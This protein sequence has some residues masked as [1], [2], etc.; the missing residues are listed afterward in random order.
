MLYYYRMV[1]GMKGM[2]QMN[3]WKKNTALF[4]SSQAISLFG[5][6]VVSFAIV[7]FVTRQTHSGLWVSLFTISSYLPQFVVSFFAGYGLIG[8]QEKTDHCSGYNDCG[9]H[10]PACT[11]D[12]AVYEY[13]DNDGS[14]NCNI[15]YSFSRSGSSDPGSSCHDTVTC[16]RR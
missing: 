8:I 1:R 9:F 13:R 11:S 7:W 15:I 14:I 4:L 3:N 6:S 2:P 12:P 16:T 10:L 5:S